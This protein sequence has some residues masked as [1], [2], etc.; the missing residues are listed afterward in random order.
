[1]QPGDQL[2][3]SSLAARCCAA[4]PALRASLVESAEANLLASSSALLNR[5][6]LVL[7]RTTNGIQIDVASPASTGNSFVALPRWARRV[8]LFVCRRQSLTGVYLFAHLEPD[9]S[10]GTRQPFECECRYAPEARIVA[11]PVAARRRPSQFAGLGGAR[12]IGRAGKRV[13]KLWLARR[14]GNKARGLLAALKRPQRAVCALII[15]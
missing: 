5:E 14:R 13:C 8:T 11:L 10:F 12:P 7:R 15:N 9:K 6:R 1:M 4:S 3:L 2:K